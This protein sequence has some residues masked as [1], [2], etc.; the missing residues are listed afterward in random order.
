VH[1]V[2][3]APGRDSLAA[4]RAASGFVQKKRFLARLRPRRKIAASKSEQQQLADAALVRDSPL[5]D[6]AWYI[7]SHPELAA[8][9]AD[10]VLHYVLQGAAAGADPGPWFDS[11][12]Y[13]TAHPVSG[14]N[15]LAQAIRKGHVEGARPPE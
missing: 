11:A 14:G 9:G 5:F 13:R 10:P 4:L 15:P 8:S 12:A 7:A 2:S 6:A 1:H 3:A